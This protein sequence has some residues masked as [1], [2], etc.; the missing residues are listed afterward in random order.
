MLSRK[1]IVDVHWISERAFVALDLERTR[2]I[3][4]LFRQTT[5]LSVVSNFLKTKGLTFSAGSWDEMLNRRIIPS[6]ESNAITNADLVE[7]LRSV[8]ECGRQHVFL[9][10]CPSQRAIELLDKAR[11]API[12]DSLGL[13]HLL[14]EPLVLEQPS[15]P[16][17]VDVRWESERAELNLTIKEIEQRAYSKFVGTERHGN[18]LHKV[19]E[20]VSERAVNLAKLHRDGL[21]EIRLASHANNSKYEADIHRF[22]LGISSILPRKDFSRISFIIAKDRLWS[23]RAS[24][25]HLIRYSDSTL[26]DQHGG[27]L[28]AATGSDV[29]DLVANPALGNSL[30]F[31]LANDKNSYC[32]GANFWFR[33]TANLSSEI[34]VLLAGDPN[35]F[36]L[37]SNCSAGDYQYVLDQLRFFN[38]SVS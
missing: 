4:E 2:K 33:K 21:L 27:V 1:K 35:E 5:S 22:W 17:I 10:A 34:H 31:L 37:P 19:Y 25:G 18:N 7:L 23:E 24:L 3:V 32:D 13:S 20:D 28:R 16:E 11:V 15:K 14:V 29:G 8:E 30:D 26:R 12:L 36:A 38:Q 6:V 9:F